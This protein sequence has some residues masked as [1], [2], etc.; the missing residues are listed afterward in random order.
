MGKNYK[1]ELDKLVSKETVNFGRQR[2]NVCVY[3][4]DE[5]YKRLQISREFRSVK[6]DFWRFSNV[7]RYT[8]EEMVGI[9]PLI[10]KAI[11]IM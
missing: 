9:L 1:P 7:G 3:I 10:Q 5:I 4:Y 11:E 2:L 8:K 6:E